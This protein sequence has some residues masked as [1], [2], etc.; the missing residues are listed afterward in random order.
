MA[1]PMQVGVIGH[2]YIRRLKQFIV[3]NPKY[4]NLCVKETETKVQFRAQGGLTISE[5]APFVL[6]D[7]P[8][9]RGCVSCRLV[10][11]T[12]QRDLLKK[13]LKTLSRMQILYCLVK[14]S[15]VL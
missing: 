13:S 5:F 8:K 1:D 11:M 10:E 3:E 6:V 2:S 4:S 15:H 14:V 12:R 9:R 7:V